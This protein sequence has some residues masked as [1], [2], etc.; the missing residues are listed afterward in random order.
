[1][2]TIT[3]REQALKVA[4]GS[5]GLSTAEAML[6]YSHVNVKPNVHVY[7]CGA[8]ITTN[9]EYKKGGGAAAGDDGA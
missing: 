9:V 8:Q 5:D 2:P 1:M 4:R 3:T 7:H 6:R